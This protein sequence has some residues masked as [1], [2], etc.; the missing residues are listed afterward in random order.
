MAETI[1]KSEYT[2]TTVCSARSSL[3]SLTVNDLGTCIAFVLKFQKLLADERFMKHVRARLDSDLF[4]EKVLDH[5]CK[6][7]VRSYTVQGAQVLSDALGKA[8][9]RLCR[10]TFP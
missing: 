5:D 10:I 2:P 8:S 4:C 7:F 9:E 1:V 3:C 6:P